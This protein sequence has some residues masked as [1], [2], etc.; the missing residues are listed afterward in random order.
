MGIAQAIF[1]VVSGLGQGRLGITAAGARARPACVCASVCGN[2][3]VCKGGMCQRSR[4]NNHTWHT[5]T[6]N[7]TRH[8]HTHTHA[9]TRKAE[10]T[11]PAA[12][13]AVHGVLGAAAAES[14]RREHAA[15]DEAQRQAREPRAKADLC[16]VCVRV[17]AVRVCVCARARVRELCVCT[18]VCTN[19]A[20]RSRWQPAAKAV[21]RHAASTRL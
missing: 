1:G 12:R 18:R 6:H 13:A 15:A 17:C 19:A 3:W 4:S 8:T 10:R 5:H 9:H 14:E 2:G 21:A 16:A 20:R 7:H 11:H